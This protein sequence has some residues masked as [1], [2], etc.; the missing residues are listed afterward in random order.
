MSSRSIS[1]LQQALREQIE[2]IRLS[3]EAYDL[4]VLAE[5]KRIAVALTNLFIDRGQTVSILTQL[6]IQDG[7]M[8]YDT[9]RKYFM[10]SRDIIVAL[11][12]G[13]TVRYVPPFGENGYKLS[14]VSDWLSGNIFVTEQ[15]QM[16]RKELILLLRDK[17]GG[18]HF[19]S[20]FT[21]AAYRLFADA[22]STDIEYARNSLGGFTI[23]AWS[24]GDRSLVKPATLHVSNGPPSLSDVSRMP[25]DIVSDYTLVRGAHLA[26]M[27]QMAWEVESSI[28]NLFAIAD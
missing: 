5:A 2:Y 23:R 7:V 13:D 27:R 22:G 25:P 12:A 3:S 26:T 8:I 20:K 6:N 14:T 17:D 16:T 4:G 15:F 18:G 28:G 10:Y 19:D 21:N 24:A 11:D 9:T 1:D